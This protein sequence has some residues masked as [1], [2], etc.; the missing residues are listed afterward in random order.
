MMIGSDGILTTSRLINLSHCSCPAPEGALYGLRT[1]SR[2]VVTWVDS[3][4]ARWCSMGHAV[5]HSSIDQKLPLGRSDRTDCPSPTWLPARGHYVI[6]DSKTPLPRCPW[7]RERI[8]FE[9]DGWQQL[10]WLTD[11]CFS[12]RS[13]SE[14]KHRAGNEILRQIS[15]I[16]RSN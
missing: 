6:Q 3:N 14:M 1:K 9:L 15:Q 4:D 16:I 8:Q 13:R 7:R 11:W 10:A 12:S 5:S 2:F